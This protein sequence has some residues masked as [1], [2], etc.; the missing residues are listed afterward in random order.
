MKKILF[1]SFILSVCFSLAAQEKFMNIHFG[2]MAPKDA[3]TGFI[4]GLV[5]GLAVDDV[6]QAGI[7]LDYYY[8]SFSE[9]RTVNVMGTQNGDR[10]GL[11]PTPKKSLSEVKINY[12]PLLANINVSIP[13]EDLPVIPRFAF[14]L[15]WGL[16]WENIYAVVEAD[17]EEDRE[18]NDP[19]T[20]LIDKTNFFHGFNWKISLGAKYPLGTRSFFNSEI[21]YNGGVMK[22]SIKKDKTGITWDEVDMSGLGLRLGIEF[23]F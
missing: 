4:G 18:N 1:I 13:A 17:S 8:K 14:G 20:T 2:F 19:E 3:K 6:V 9:N 21:V 23:T 10:Q 16:L 11:T 15:G 5:Y 7:G 22:S 12:L